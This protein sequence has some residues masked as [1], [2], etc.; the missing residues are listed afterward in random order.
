METLIDT[1]AMIL[2]K[3]SVSARKGEKLLISI[4]MR[5]GSLVCVGKGNEDW[6]YSAPHG[7]GRV[8]GRKEARYKL[9]LED[10]EKSMEGIWSSTVCKNTLDEAPMVYKDMSEIVANI[11]R[12]I[13][14]F[15]FSCIVQTLISVRFTAL[16]LMRKRKGGKIKKDC[17]F[18]DS[19]SKMLFCFY[20]NYLIN[21]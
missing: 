7:A 10:F 21:A 11:E 8:M 14:I 6:N 17:R 15:R 18:F 4:N 12:S 5:D 13:L 3:G 9:K 20:K 1:D 19:L 16:F 2:R